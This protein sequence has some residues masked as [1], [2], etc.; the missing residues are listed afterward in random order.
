MP[1]TYV[2]NSEGCMKVWIVVKDAEAL[3]AALAAW[4]EGCPGGVV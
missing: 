4:R 3:R 2:P 1:S